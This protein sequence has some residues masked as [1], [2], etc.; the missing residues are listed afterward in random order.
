MFKLVDI[1]VHN[2]ETNLSFK[3]IFEL[4][5]IAVQV[6]PDRI[7]KTVLPGKTSDIKGG[8]YVILDQ[9]QLTQ[10]FE[11]IKNSDD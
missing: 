11:K 2:C 8:S 4:A 6:Q 3:E 7:T 10:T 5:K 1:L 9:N